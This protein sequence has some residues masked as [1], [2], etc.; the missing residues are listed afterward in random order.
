MLAGSVVFFW[1]VSRANKKMDAV[2]NVQIGER[3]RSLSNPFFQASE[4]DLRQEALAGVMK[5]TLK[6]RCFLPFS[7]F[8]FF[9]FFYFFVL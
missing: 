7:F 3:K 9:L 6:K 1:L 4:E 2:S 8:F 5:V